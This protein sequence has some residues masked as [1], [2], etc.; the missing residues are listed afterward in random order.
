L[1]CV[2]YVVINPLIRKGVSLD[3]IKKLQPDIFILN[4]LE[5]EKQ[6]KKACPSVELV[7]NTETKIISTTKIIKRCRYTNKS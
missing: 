7:L 4:T 2:D 1:N 6:L 3:T 5:K